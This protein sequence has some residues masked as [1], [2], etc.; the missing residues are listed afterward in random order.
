[1][2]VPKVG[3]YNN[4]H[5][6]WHNHRLPVGSLNHWPAQVLQVAV[7]CKVTPGQRVLQLINAVFA[8]VKQKA[9]SG[10]NMMCSL[11][12]GTSPSFAAC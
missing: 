1:M 2:F 6:F 10:H 8:M 12:E 7:T 4:I 11:F 3:V 5:V 9:V